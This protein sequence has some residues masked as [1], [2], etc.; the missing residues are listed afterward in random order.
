MP[1]HPQSKNERVCV[2]SKSE[3]Q[4]DGLQYMSN[5]LSDLKSLF[6]KRMDIIF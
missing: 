4:M 3:F 1:H 2:M 6:S 5:I